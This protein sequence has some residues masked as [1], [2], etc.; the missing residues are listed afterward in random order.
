MAAAKRRSWAVAG[1][2]LLDE[3]ALAAGIRWDRCDFDRRLFRRKGSAGSNG[4]HP[5]SV[6][7]EVERPKDRNEL[8]LVSCVARIVLVPAP[9]GS[10]GKRRRQMGRFHAQIDRETQMGR[11]QER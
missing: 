7:V 9:L 10:T 3:Q 5:G 6:G 4:I 2:L 8:V 1:L 11:F